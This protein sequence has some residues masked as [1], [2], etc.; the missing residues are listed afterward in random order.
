MNPNIN[1]TTA[2]LSSIRMLYAAAVLG[3]LC[4]TI[5]AS[6]KISVA[7]MQLQDIDKQLTLFAHE[8]D[9]SGI[10]HTAE[11]AELMAKA[12]DYIDGLPSP[13][14]IQVCYN[15]QKPQG[16]KG[17]LRLEFPN[18]CGLKDPIYLS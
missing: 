14:D 2:N 8:E 12:Q 7:L 17:C 9:A 5:D 1:A 11:S 13:V 16:V 6:S 15:D 18:G 4:G 3:S 10:D